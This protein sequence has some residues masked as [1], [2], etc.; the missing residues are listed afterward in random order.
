M[1]SAVLLI[2]NDEFEAHLQQFGERTFVHCAVLAPWTKSLRFT[3]Q[4]H[5]N[6][7]MAWRKDPLFALHTVGDNKHLTFLR[8][9]E[10]T[11]DHHI[12]D[13]PDNVPRMV[14]KRKQKR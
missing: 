7:I 12:E 10:F 13:T 1:N 14:Y 5:L 3:I 11:F 2:E 4:E 6:Q 8:I 9:M